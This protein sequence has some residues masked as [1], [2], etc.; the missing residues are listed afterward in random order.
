[1]TQRMKKLIFVISFLVLA[2][3]TLAGTDSWTSGTAWLVYFS[4]ACFVG[5]VVLGLWGSRWGTDLDYKPDLTADDIAQITKIRDEKDHVAAVKSLR[6]RY[7]RLTLVN[8][9]D[10]VKSL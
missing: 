2:C 3:V 6:E 5:Y 4:F 1:M 8:A 7:P 9:N 10:M